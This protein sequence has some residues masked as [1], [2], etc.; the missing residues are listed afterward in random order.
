MACSQMAAQGLQV[1]NLSGGI[2][3]WPYWA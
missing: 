2:M 1:Y 3:N